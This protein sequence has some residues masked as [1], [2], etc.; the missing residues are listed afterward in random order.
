[1]KDEGLCSGNPSPQ[2]SSKC[3]GERL[4]L[5]EGHTAGL[6]SKGQEFLREVP[7]SNMTQVLRISNNGS[8]TLPSVLRCS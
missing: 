7:F 2:T 4:G 6:S 5:P 8:E 3:W 1:M